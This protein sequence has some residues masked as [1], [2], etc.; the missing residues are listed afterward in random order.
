MESA[1]S[2]LSLVVRDGDPSPSILIQSNAEMDFAQEQ[3]EHGRRGTQAY[4]SCDLRASSVAPF[5]M[6]RG[7]EM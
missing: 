1:A 2:A 5:I 4:L 3:T 7:L 6:F